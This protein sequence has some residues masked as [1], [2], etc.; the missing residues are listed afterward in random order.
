MVEEFVLKL[1]MAFFRKLL[2]L[3]RATKEFIG[4][5]SESGANC[6]SRATAIKFLLARKFDVARAHALWRQH[7]ATRRREGLTKFQPD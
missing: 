6:V 4:A 5:L 3:L 1:E 7:E 2:K